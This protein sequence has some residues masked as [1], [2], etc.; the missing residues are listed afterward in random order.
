[1]LPSLDS[2][3]K[4]TKSI[5]LARGLSEDGWCCALCSRSELK[6]IPV[7]NRRVDLFDFAGLISMGRDVRLRMLR[8]RNGLEKVVLH[9]HYVCWHISDSSLLVML[10]LALL[11]L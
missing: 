10:R 3:V 8:F 11:N 5:S 9:L 2:R 1:V 6:S 4:G 7:D